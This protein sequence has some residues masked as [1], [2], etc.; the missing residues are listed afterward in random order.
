MPFFI[1]VDI[2]G[3]F[4]DCAV[5]DDAGIVHIGKA[6]TTPDD[7]MRGCLDSIAAAAAKV[8]LSLSEL[9]TRSSRFVHGTTI[10]L[11]AITARSGPK[12]GLLTTRGHG[13]AIFIMNGGGRTTGLDVEQ[14]GYYPG[15]R[16]PEPLIDAAFVREIPE[17]VD[18]RGEVVV[19]LNEGVLDEAI[20]Q[21]VQAEVR[22]IAI[23]FLWSFINPDHELRAKARVAA[24]APHVYA[25]CSSELIPILGEFERVAATVLNSYVG[26]VMADYA[27][28][29]QA[30]IHEHGFRH[31]LQFVHSAGGVLSR[32]SAER[33]PIQTLNSGPVGGVLGSAN[34]GTQLGLS[35]IITADMG[36]TTFDVGIIHNGQPL[37]RDMSAVAQ[38]ELHLPM[39][40]VQSIGA[41]G[42]SIAWIDEAG[43]LKVG[44]RSAG[45]V[46]GPACYGTG[47]TDATVTDA[48]LVLGMINGDRFLD[49]RVPLDLK[50]ART[51]ICRIADRVGQSVDETAAGIALIADANMAALIRRM[52]LNQGFDPRE[53]TLFAFGG[54]GPLHAGSYAREMNLK[55]VII[56][57]GDSASVWSALGAACGDLVHVKTRAVHLKAPFNA[58]EVGA[59]LKSLEQDIIAQFGSEG[60]GAGAVE[61][62]RFALMKFGLQVHE[63][64][65]P[66]SSGVLR[67][68]AMATLTDAFIAKY[69]S[70]YGK[71]S[72]YLPGGVHIT[73]VRVRGRSPGAVPL[74][75]QDTNTTTDIP[76]AAKREARHVYWHE[77]NRRVSTPVYEGNHLQFGNR[78][79]GPAIVDMP[80]TTI[81]VRP[82]QTLSKD[83]FANFVLQV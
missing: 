83:A 70:K 26:P 38:H 33:Y 72:A 81:A 31:E 35:S 68:S 66:I 2:G 12:I 73:G 51:A 29:L 3:T 52:T 60:V 49:G 56:P 48:D 74:L 32:Y 79:A 64:E 46:P 16:N 30:A 4:T 10:G 34:L 78:I 47:G 50:R 11:N 55:S 82:G 13:D 80:D 71:G 41:G 58:A 62:S 1:G 22:A 21:L 8:G 19:P 23:C 28:R 24:Q 15:T 57:M 17:R 63:V 9:M 44:P 61:L 53:F 20:E 5:L 40:D 14:L 59:V 27:S 76:A 77:E 65:T 37:A 18:S 7:P 36:G 54:G 39:V 45:A 43:G 75:R 25:C 69:E 42:G 6:P 67:D